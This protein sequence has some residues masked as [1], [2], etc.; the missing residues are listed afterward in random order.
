MICSHLARRA[1]GWV[2]T[3]LMVYLVF[4]GALF[5]MQKRLMYFPDAARFAP[6]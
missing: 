3:L 6:T 4:I 2:V 5:L 1:A